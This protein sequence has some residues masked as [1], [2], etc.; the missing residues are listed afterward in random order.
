MESPNT[1]DSPEQLT[2][3]ARETGESLYGGTRDT[4]LTGIAIIVPIAVTLYVLAMVL[5]VIADAFA[6]IVGLLEYLGVIEQFERIELIRLLVDLGIYSLVIDF[7]TELITIFILLAVIL[8]VGSVGRN[9]YGERIIDGVDLAITSIPGVGTVYRSFRRMGDVVLNEDAE[10]FQEVKLIQCLDEDIYV[11]GF[12]TSDAPATIEE[13]TGHDDMVAMFLPLAP[14][15][16]TGGFLTYVPQSNVHDLDMT[17]E[18][19]V[20]SILT[21][22]IAADEGADETTPLAM[23]DLGKVANFQHLQDTIATEHDERD[24]ES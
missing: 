13:S 22:G 10:N 9:R 17:I 11:L 7:L 1:P 6:P 15:P 3:A 4:I 20:R 18:E 19:G 5:N 16:V 14:N 12:K 23:G 24:G 2:T 21:S 8:V